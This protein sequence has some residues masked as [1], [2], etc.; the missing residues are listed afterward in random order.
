MVTFDVKHF[1]SNALS[2]LIIFVLY[3]FCF[4]EMAFEYLAQDLMYLEHRVRR[5]ERRPELYELREDHDH[6]H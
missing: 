2:F 1:Y 6:D 5:L 3:V 4:S